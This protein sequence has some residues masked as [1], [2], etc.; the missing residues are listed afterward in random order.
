MLRWNSDQL[1]QSLLIH[2]AHTN[3]ERK[4]CTYAKT[5]EPSLE[6]AKT[7]GK[8]FPKQLLPNSE[9]LTERLL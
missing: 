2:F 6:I 1:L 3:V 7:D 9:W 8:R 4:G 5:H